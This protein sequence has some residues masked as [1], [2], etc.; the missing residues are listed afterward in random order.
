MEVGQREV[1]RAGV[2]KGVE[3][4]AETGGAVRTRT[5]AVRKSGAGH[6]SAGASTIVGRPAAAG[7]RHQRVVFAG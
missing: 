3:L 4:E 5:L 7:R 2:V 1:V 6:G